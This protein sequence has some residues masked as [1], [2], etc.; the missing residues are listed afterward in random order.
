MHLKENEVQ[1][2]TETTITNPQ[3]HGQFLMSKASH[4]CLGFITSL[5]MINLE[6]LS[7]EF[8]VL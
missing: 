3:L 5:S 7:F 6:V 2:L 8:I 1:Q 4:R